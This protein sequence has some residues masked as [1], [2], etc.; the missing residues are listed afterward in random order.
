MDVVSDTRTSPVDRSGQPGALDGGAPRVVVGVDGSPG[1]RNALT[2]A[3]FEAAR[4]AAKLDVVSAF[5]VDVGWAGG[6]PLDIPDVEAV[7]ADVELR[8]R[9]LVE[10]VRGDASLTP[11]AGVDAVPVR[12]RAVEGR[13]VPALLAASEGADLLVV[14]NR[15]RGAI[16]SALLGSVA[17]HCVSHASCPVIVVHGGAP[18][19]QPSGV[20]VGVDGSE[21]SRAALV[22]ALDA[23]ARIGSDVEVVACYLRADYWTDYAMLVVPEVEQI[24]A[25]LERHTEELVRGILADR[26]SGETVPAVRVEVVE[27]AAGDVLVERSEEGNLLVVGSR[28]RGA[29]RGLLVGSVALHCAMHG[30]GPVMV[31]H[32]QRAGDRGA[33]PRVGRSSADR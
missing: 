25:D 26:G 3:F 27:G 15:G 1:G 20:V 11:V 8:A 31:V 17:V 14:G 24:R 23:A 7:R 30:S 29:V 6:V 19:P 28:G 21:S 22:A 9:E 5:P 13:P 16:R 33:Q 4:R 10:Q 18:A 2:L 12:V 32:P